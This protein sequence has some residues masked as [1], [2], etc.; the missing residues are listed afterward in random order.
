MRRT[1]LVFSLSM[2]V[3]C[4]VVPCALGFRPAAGSPFAT[5][6]DALS[7]SPHGRWLASADFKGVTALSI[8]PSVGAAHVV[9][10]VR[11]PQLN[12]VSFSP[13]GRL[14]A[15][16]NYEG[17]LFVLSFNGKTGALHQLSRLSLHRP[18]SGDYAAAVAF[19]PHGGLLAIADDER[20]RLF[21]VNHTTGALHEL[22]VPRPPFYYNNCPAF[23]MVFSPHRNLFVAGGSDD[24]EMCSFALNGRTGGVKQL[25]RVLLPSGPPGLPVFSQDGR[26]IAIPLNGGLSMLSVGQRDGKLRKLAVWPNAFQASQP[27]AFS[28]NGALLATATES[29]AEPGKVIMY[30]VNQ[31]TGA[32]QTPRSAPL[33]T[34]KFPDTIAFDPRGGLL[35]VGTLVGQLWVFQNAPMCNEPEHDSTCG[36]VTG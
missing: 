8:N 29:G 31:R 36:R 2:V 14:I 5:G 3:W 6:G 7:F 12:T 15:A 17:S 30:P 9:A 26:L 20:V 1:G 33:K 25:S 27:V 16:S 24:G 18:G 4:A 19:S 11:I 10:H 28:P 21:R 35:A 34:G 32:L 13:D 22:N 23:S